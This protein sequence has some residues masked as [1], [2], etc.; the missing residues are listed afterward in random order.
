MRRSHTLPLL[1]FGLVVGA[2]LLAGPAASRA[3]ESPLWPRLPAWALDPAQIEERLGG[4]T[5]PS[6]P[7]VSSSVGASGGALTSR[8]GLAAPPP[9][10]TPARRLT[11]GLQAGHWRRWEAPYP[12]NTHTGSQGGGK[13]EDEVNLT[14][15]RLAA[16]RLEAAGFRVEILPTLIPQGY[17]AAVV[18]SI[19]ADGGPPDRRGFFADR[20]ARSAQAAA[21]ARLVALLNEEYARATGIPYVYRGTPGTRYYYG[22]TLVDPSTPMALIET[23]FLTSATDRAIIVDRPDRAAQGIAQAIQRFLTE[24]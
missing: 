22:Y 19:H 4:S 17:R 16:Q 3:A 23:G 24:R 1:V 8:G 15:A 5:A 10:P 12:F 21:E 7:P 13:T 2:L 20:P 9:T 6:P 11:V 14:I 18:V